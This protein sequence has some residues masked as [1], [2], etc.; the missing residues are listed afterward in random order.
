RSITNYVTPKMADTFG[1]AVTSIDIDNIE[2]D[3]TSEGYR[4]L[5]EIT[6]DITSQTIKAQSAINLQNMQDMQ[7]IN[8]ENMAETLRIQREEAQR[9]QEYQTKS[10][11]ISA[12]QLEKQ[13]EVGI[14]GA[15][16]LGQMG[17]NGA[18]N[19]DMGGGSSLNPAAMMTGMAMGGAIGSNMAG[20][21]NNM[22][23]GMN[24]NMG[25]NQMNGM[26]G[27]Q[28]GMMPPPPP[29]SNEVK[30]NIAVNGQTLGPYGMNELSAMAAQGQIN[31]ATKVWRAGM[32]GWADAGTVAELQSIFAQVPPPPPAP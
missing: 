23:G 30:F 8:A 25:M 5:R 28:S 2:V 26:N 18:M 29:P 21:M 19:M 7:R 15:N 32:P 13:A 20:M 17:A 3:K 9:A 6:A 22:M 31:S 24:P 11:N 4:A 14:A 27:L 1:G 16:A 12:Y 10:A